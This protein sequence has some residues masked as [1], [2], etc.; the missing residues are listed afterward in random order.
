VNQTGQIGDGTFSRKDAPARVAAHLDLVALVTGWFHTCALDIDGQIYCWGDNSGGAL[1]DVGRDPQSVPV[2]IPSAPDIRV[3][4]AGAAHTCALDARGASYC[5][6]SNS[7]GQLGTLEIV[8]GCGQGPCSSRPVR[9]A[10]GI[11]FKAITAGRAH[12]CGVTSD[13]AAYCWGSNQG[14]KLGIGTTRSTA[15]PALVSGGQVFLQVSAGGTHTCGLTTSRTLY[16]WGQ[17]DRG[18]LGTTDTP[19]DCGGGGFPCSTRPVP[20][21]TDLRFTMVDAGGEHT[22]A[23]TDG[24]VTYCWGASTEGQLG[25]GFIT[26]RT[27]PLRI[28]GA[29]TLQ[30]VTAGERHTCG[31]A[32]DGSVYCW[33]ENFGSQLGIGRPGLPIVEPRL[34]SFSP[35]SQ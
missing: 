25:Y 12:N 7:N 13:G 11:A 14:G 9:V 23:L 8:D 2:A 29:L 3:L 31:V 27:I 10:G 32:Q 4:V 1:G 30:S 21:S 20:V 17:N 6:G 15:L 33:G 34:I 35:S 18:Q 5:W 26:D 22:C 19:N 16:C 28:A 24:G